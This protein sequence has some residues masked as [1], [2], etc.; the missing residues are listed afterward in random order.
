MIRRVGTFPLAAALLT[1]SVFAHDFWIEPSSYH[2]SKGALLKVGLQVGDHFQGEPVPRQES[3]IEQFV[4]VG[5]SDK[6]DIKGLDGSD[7]AG[8]LRVPEE[9]SLV[10]GYRSNHAF[11]ELAPKKFDAY[12]E[13][14]GLESILKQRAKLAS[15]E[16]LVREA[17]SRCAKSI[18]VSGESREGFD[19][20]LG[21]PLELIP[22]EDPTQRRSESTT[23][24][25]LFENKPLAGVQ[26]S[27]LSR[28]EK[29]K[30]VSARTDAN[31]QVSLKLDESGV[32]LVKAVHMRKAPEGIEA[33][34]ES[35]WASLTFEVGHQQ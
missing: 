1:S 5:A 11:I 24:T 18:V 21:F 23:F 29:G 25:L 28:D 12:L 35:F 7:P 4:I 34:W 2:T 22:R 14:E 31:G 33:D 13:E 16:A 9:G 20:R 10:L 30:R 17:Y 32:W 27:A 19:R 3:R 26:V 6:Q 8:L 15:S